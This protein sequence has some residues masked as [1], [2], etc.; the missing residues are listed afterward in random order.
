MVVWEDRNS[1]QTEKPSWSEVRSVKSSF[2]VCDPEL[3][4]RGSW[5][6]VLWSQPAGCSV[7]AGG[8]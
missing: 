6:D 7:P 8:K 4:P 1:N 2:V 5:C 3:E